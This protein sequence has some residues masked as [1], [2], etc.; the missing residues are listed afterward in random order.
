MTL[1]SF[2]LEGCKIITVPYDWK[3]SWINDPKRKMKFPKRPFFFSFRQWKNH[4][5]VSIFGMIF[6]TKLEITGQ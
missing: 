6:L 2:D 3:N 1:K 4:L 5:P